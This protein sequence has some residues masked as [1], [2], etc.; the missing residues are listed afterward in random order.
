MEL[1]SIANIYAKF[2]MQMELKD[3]AC[4]VP[5]TET[6]LDMFR[7]PQDCSFCEGI[8]HEDRIAN[9]SAEEFKEKY[10][11]SG[12]VTVVTDGTKNWTASKYF[13]LGFF[14]KVYSKGSPALESSSKDCQFFRYNTDFNTLQ[15]VFDMPRKMRK[16]EGKSWYVGW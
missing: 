6:F 3:E 7:P 9:L 8:H 4:L 16:M 5:T 1:K 10:A 15:E 13:S 12:R 11:Y 2:F 14:K